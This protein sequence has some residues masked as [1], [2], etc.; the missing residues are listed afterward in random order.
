MRDGIKIA[1]GS[2]WWLVLAPVIIALM[3]LFYFFPALLRGPF[4]EP[5][6]ASGFVKSGEIYIEDTRLIHR[7]ALPGTYFV[8]IYRMAPEPPTLI[9]NGPAGKAPYRPSADPQSIVLDLGY[10]AGWKQGSGRQNCPAAYEA[11]EIAVDVVW[12]E[13]HIAG[14]CIGEVSLDELIFVDVRELS[15]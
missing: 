9:C 1:L 2:G 10:Y 13:R 7:S 4:L 6:S 12:C 8:K 5:V 15:E 3:V 14:M 11:D